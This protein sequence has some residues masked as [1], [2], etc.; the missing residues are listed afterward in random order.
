MDRRR[1][2]LTAAGVAVLGGCG[3]GGGE[4]AGGVFFPPLGAAPPPTGAP[5]AAVPGAPAPNPPVVNPP[6]VNPPVP[7][8]P[9]PPAGPEL[10]T[11]TSLPAS[12][13][14]AQCIA[15][16][17][18]DRGVGPGQ[19]NFWDLNP[20]FGIQSGSNDQFAGAM[21]L[22]VKVGTRSAGFDG[23]QT[24][25]ELTALGP[26]MTAAD[27][28]K[29]VSIT[30]DPPFQ[31]NDDTAFLHAVPD[32]RL[33]QTIDLTLATGRV[34]A[35]WSGMYGST[36]PP[37]FNDEETFMQVV[38]R[39]TGGTLLST[40]YRVDSNGA[41]GTWGFAWITAYTGRVVVLSFEQSGRG[42]GTSIDDVTVSDSAP[43]AREFIVNGDFS[44]GLAGWTVSQARV[45]QNIR[46]GT[47]TLRG[48]AVQRTF[49]AQP[50]LLWARLTDT[51]QNPGASSVTAVVTYTSFLGSYGA[52]VIYPTPG[53]PQKGLTV[54]DG[55]GGGRDAGFV[56]GSADA[57]DF[58]SASML[59]ASDG[60]NRVDI[61]FNI[62]VP[63]GGTATLANFVI[64][65]GTNTWIGAT[66]TTARATDVD[67]QAA[68]IAAGFRTDVV[69]QRGLTQVQLDT[70][71]NF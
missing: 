46:S 69:Y 10:A 52:G 34:N 66:D 59:N 60:N 18:N 57:V 16:S 15:N 51:F 64:L 25:A 1:F 9:A 50:N 71:K 31:A 44:A 4:G 12:T 36:L 56:F 58:T 48:L 39:D 47:R 3:G 70:L 63:A 62:T 68:A 53:A 40:L 49:Y 26:E 14:F 28:L 42:L 5:P 20:Y 22:S 45:A 13:T 23:D 41:V 27:G 24:F 21:S 8:P 29:V 2:A 11:P 65:T 17:D 55:M 35:S 43:R 6:V 7:A 54:W 33:Q 37:N 38:L 19:A 67:T 32:V 30:T 61:R